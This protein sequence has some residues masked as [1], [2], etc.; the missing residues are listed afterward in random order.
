M[1]PIRT[2]DLLRLRSSAAMA[3]LALAIAAC[4]A[5]TAAAPSA[6]P[7]ATATPSPWPSPSQPSARPSTAPS[8][9]PSPSPS[10]SPGIA[11]A[12]SG[13]WSRVAWLDAG[14]LPFDAPSSP[15]ISIQGWSGGY[16]AL[17]QTSGYDEAGNEL[18]VTVRVSTSAD[19]VHW[20]KPAAIDTAGF[21]GSIRIERIVE[22]PSGLLAL[23]YPYGDTCGGPST[24]Q[25]VWTSTD[26][27]RWERV[28][29]P[30]GMASGQVRTVAGGAAGYIAFGSAADTTRAALWTSL[31]GRTWQSRPLPTVSSGTLVLDGATSFDGGFVVAGA[32]LGEEGCGGAAHIRAAAWWSA[33]GAAWTRAKLP[34][35]LTDPDAR[36]AVL[37]LTGSALLAI[38]VS[39]DG[40]TRLAWTSDDGRTWTATNAPSEL[41]ELRAVS[42][43]RHTA[44]LFEAE[45]A[46]PAVME[47]REDGETVVL[48]PDGERPP[49]S[50]DGPTWSLAVGPTGLLAYR[51]DGGGVFLGL[52]S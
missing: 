49:I 33:D 35:S 50:E 6:S 17:A 23:A 30:K 5:P 10:A 7:G 26:G 21:K 40:E 14:K 52:P 38:Q 11:L 2:L 34:G 37:P 31:D 36:L 45:A 15:E 24:L 29:L 44:G 32:V 28:S 41:M 27:A 43:G 39:P 12:P 18:P 4:S 3:I 8:V 22:G 20:S 47:L 13:P 25:A 16:V 46:G 42:D 9:P 19:G 48:E 1:Y 51:F